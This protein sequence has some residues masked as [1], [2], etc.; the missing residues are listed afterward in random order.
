MTRPS[1]L[2]APRAARGVARGDGLCMR[3]GGDRGA[4]NRLKHFE[5]SESGRRTD[6]GIV[7]LLPCCI[8]RC[9]VLYPDIDGKLRVG[10]QGEVERVLS[11]VDAVLLVVDAT[12]GPMSQTKVRHHVRMGCRLTDQLKD[13]KCGCHHEYST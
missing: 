8:A 5:V 6:S 4:L 2:R 13:D 1:H 3:R 10:T 7:G 11:M 9:H 12:E